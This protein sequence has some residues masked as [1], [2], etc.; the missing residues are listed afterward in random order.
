MLAQYVNSHKTTTNGR[1]NGNT[2]FLA[3]GQDSLQV[4]L[5]T[6]TPE[7]AQQYLDASGGNRSPRKSSINMLAKAMANNEWRL[8]GQAIIFNDDMVL[9]DGHHR[10]AACVQAKTSFKTLVIRNVRKN[11]L[12]SIDIGGKRSIGDQLCFIDKSTYA[13]SNIV[14]TVYKRIY[15]YIN[16]AAKP[17]ISDQQMINYIEET[18]GSWCDP[19]MYQAAQRNGLNGSVINAASFLLKESGAPNVD[20][21]IHKLITG[22]MLALHDPIHTLRSR[23]LLDKRIQMHEYN[24]VIS[25][26]IRSY[27]YWIVGKKMEKIYLLTQ[28]YT[29]PKF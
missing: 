29:E 19:H 7:K 24:W 12:T 5:E 27:N 18:K 4:S 1:T 23:M 26:V 6:I 9:I 25:S 3:N 22:E 16:K 13:N 20:V 21:F 10:L 15:S 28:N 2:A 17:L 8:T 11:A 14:A